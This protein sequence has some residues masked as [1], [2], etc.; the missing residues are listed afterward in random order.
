MRNALPDL[1]D[2][3]TPGATIPVRVT[4]NASR[5]A[6]THENGCIRIIVAAAPENGRA[7]AASAKLLGKALGVA[8][9][10]LS[11][12]HG[13]TSRNKVFRLD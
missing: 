9:S 6:I 11:L 10:R 7:N 3:A 13:A 2:L 8:K 5:N 12:V 4:P 1:S